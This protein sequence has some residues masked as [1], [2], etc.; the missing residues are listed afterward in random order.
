[1]NAAA[2]NAAGRVYA[3]IP[4]RGGSERVPGKNLSPINGQPLIAWTIAAALGAASVSR[5]FVTT[6]SAEIAAVSRQCGAEVIDR[7]AALSGSSASSESALLHALDWLSERGEPAPDLIVFLQAT[8]PLRRPDDVDRAV[9]QFVAAGADSLLSVSAT[10]GFLWRVDDGV[11]APLSF[12]PA[13]RPRSQELKD[14]FVIENGSL[15]IFKAS[16][17]RETGCRLGGK[18]VAFYQPAIAAMDIDH[19]EDVEVVDA[20]MRTTGLGTASR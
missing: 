7:P 19:P 12:D 18:T 5:T 2:A 11:P 6:D 3:I 4:A 20:L 13:N 15:Y 16:L 8:S 1:M 17:L 9:E 14:R 10:P